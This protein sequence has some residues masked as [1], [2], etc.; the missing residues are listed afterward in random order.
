MNDAVTSVKLHDVVAVAAMLYGVAP[1]AMIEI[2]GFESY[3]YEYTKENQ[4]Y[5]LKIIN[6]ERRTK[7]MLLAEVEYINYLAENGISVS[8]CIPTIDGQ[9]VYKVAQF[10]FVSYEKAK[11]GK[12]SE[13]DWAPALFVQLGDIVGRMHR[14]AEVYTPSDPSYV[15]NQWHEEPRLHNFSKLLQGEPAIMK[16]GQEVLEQLHAFPV[17]PNNY[18]LIHYDCHRGNYFVADGQITL[19]DFD[20]MQYNWYVNDAAVILYYVIKGNHVG[21]SSEAI[22]E[23]VTCFLEGYTRHRM[24]EREELE[25][26]PTFLKLRQF[27]L[28]IAISEKK[29]EGQL[30]E[31]MQTRLDRIRG[32]I[33]RDEDIIDIN[34]L[35]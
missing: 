13:E 7:L 26:I 1:S 30:T 11:G 22:R 25:R 16:Y 33:E 9:Y 15:R 35:F 20:D 18:G 29:A 19:F 24:F 3:V 14:L 32:E 2:G 12:V 23:F 8:R 6:R 31:R 4:A 21:P 34:L 27:L 10:Y 5:I 28:Y 17:T